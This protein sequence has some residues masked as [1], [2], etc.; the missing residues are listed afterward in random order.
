MALDSSLSEGCAEDALEQEAITRVLKRLCSNEA[1]STFLP[2]VPKSEVQ[3]YEE[4][5]QPICLTES[6]RGAHT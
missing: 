4:I 3:Y 6:E 2:P 1:T 5:E